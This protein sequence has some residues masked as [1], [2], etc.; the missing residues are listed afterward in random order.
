[1]L[2]QFLKNPLSTI[3]RVSSE[4]VWNLLLEKLVTVFKSNTDSFAMS[5]LWNSTYILRISDILTS[6]YPTVSTVKRT[7]NKSPGRYFSMASNTIYCIN[8]SFFTKAPSPFDTANVLLGVTVVTQAAHALLNAAM[9]L[10]KKTTNAEKSEPSMRK[11][12]SI[13]PWVWYNS[14][15]INTRWWSETGDHTCRNW[16]R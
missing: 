4:E 6:V 12:I 10:L 13:S 9:D 3:Y 7:K 15:N 11:I 5:L 14:L 16:S 2:Q 1:M 8:W